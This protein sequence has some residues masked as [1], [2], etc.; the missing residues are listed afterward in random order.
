MLDYVSLNYGSVW[1]LVNS[2]IVVG[3][4]DAKDYKSHSYM[5]IYRR[6]NAKFYLK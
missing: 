3:I 4:I 1:V 6:S 5:D 2:G